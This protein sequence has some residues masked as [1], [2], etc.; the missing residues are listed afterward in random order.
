[1]TDWLKEGGANISKTKIVYESDTNRRIKAA[2]DIKKDEIAMIIPETM[3][4]RLPA[5]GYDEA[6][7]PESPEGKLQT[8]VDQVNDYKQGDICYNSVDHNRF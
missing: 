1:M 2:K 8:L 7:D 4:V 5:A 3:R 6:L